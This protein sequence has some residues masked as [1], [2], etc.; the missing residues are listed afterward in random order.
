M[1]AVREI[2]GDHANVIGQFKPN[3]NAPYS[4][5]YNSNWRNHSNFSWKPRAPQYTQPGQAP[6]QASSPEQAILNLNKVVGDFVADQKSINDQFMQ[7]N[8]QIRQENAHIMQEMANRDR[9]MDGKHN[10]LSQKIDNLQES[11]Q[12]REVK[13][14]ITLRSGK[15]VDLPTPKPEQEPETEAEKEKREETKGKKKESSTKKEDLE[16]KVNEKPERTIN[17]EEVIKKHM[18]PPFPQ[19]LHGKRGITTHQKFLKC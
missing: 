1:P 14:V 2:F 13:A 19:A 15:E 5:T 8:A 18:P 6:S 11:S 7:V 12:M 3:N 17:Q 16:A 9:R 4:N 10:D